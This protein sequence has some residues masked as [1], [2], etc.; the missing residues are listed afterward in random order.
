S[1]RFL[2]VIAW[3]GVGLGLTVVTGWAQSGPPWVPLVVFLALWAAYLSVV[4]IGQT[5]YAFGWESLLLEA[6]FLVAFL[7]SEDTAAPVTVL[8]LAR[9]LVLRL[10]LGAG[11][12]K[13]RGDTAW[14]DLSALDYHHETQPMPGPFSWH[15]H[16]LPRW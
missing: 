10:E 3:C 13:M 9:W 14:R 4:S 12:I 7:G 15:A 16:H 2:L 1:D 11:L 8:V 5:F 6:G